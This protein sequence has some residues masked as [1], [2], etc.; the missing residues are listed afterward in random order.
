MAAPNTANC[1]PPAFHYTI[2]HNRL[3]SILRT[4]R[5]EPAYRWGISRYELIH[6]NNAYRASTYKSGCLR[7]S[8]IT[9]SRSTFSW[10]ANRRNCLSSTA[11]FTVRVALR[12]RR[13]RSHRTS[14]LSRLRRYTSRIRLRERLRIT[15]QPSFLLTQKATRRP[16]RAW[17]QA[18]NTNS[19]QLADCPR[20]KTLSKCFD[21]VIV[22][23]AFNI[24]YAESRLRPF[25]RRRA[26]TLRPPEVAM[27]A[28]N[29][30]FVCLRLHLGCKVRF[31]I[32]FLHI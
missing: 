13:I 31:M 1:H 15:A 19:A 16:G 8:S 9:G 23:M 7:L 25:L 17:H 22:N 5:P 2:T 20:R 30:C 32:K 4:S 21:L 12:A 3:P 29:P 11:N 6:A 26:S 18:Y 10:P 27:R 14:N 28:K 24:I